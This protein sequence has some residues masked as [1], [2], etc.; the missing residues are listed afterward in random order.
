MVT[1]DAAIVVGESDPSCAGGRLEGGY[2]MVVGE[3]DSS[4]AGCIMEDGYA[5]T[6]VLDGG[7]TAGGRGLGGAYL[8]FMLF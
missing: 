4:C 5:I 6:V 1:G 7:I 2:T 3:G 8:L